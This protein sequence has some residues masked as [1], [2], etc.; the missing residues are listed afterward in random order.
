MGRATGRGDITSGLAVTDSMVERFGLFTIIV[1]GEVI[2]G[3]V[4]GLSEAERTAEV[5]AT[6]LLGLMIGFAFW[7]T[8]FDFAGRRLPKES[9]HD[10]LATPSG[11][12]H[13]FR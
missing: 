5:A 8:F 13:T 7:W 9:E 3:V 12:F 11:C 2:V 10:R 1:L 4:E 6:G